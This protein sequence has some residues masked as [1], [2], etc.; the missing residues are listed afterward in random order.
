MPREEF[1]RQIDALWR[2]TASRSRH[3]LTATAMPSWPVSPT[4]FELEAVVAL[5]S[6][7][8][9]IGCSSAAG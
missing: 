1:T 6:R 8:G 9:G 5:L 4:W 2:L 3:C 7:A